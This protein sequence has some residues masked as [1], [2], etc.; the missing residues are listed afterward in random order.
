MA[1]SERIQKPT[2]HSLCMSLIWVFP[3]ILSTVIDGQCRPSASLSSAS[4]KEEVLGIPVHSQ[5][6]RSMDDNLLLLGLESEVG[7]VPGD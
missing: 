1:P 7:R 3:G 6:V 2:S 4:L 5:S